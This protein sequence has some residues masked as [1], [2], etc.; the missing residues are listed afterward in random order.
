MSAMRLKLHQ[1]VLKQSKNAVLLSHEVELSC[2]KSWHTH[3]GFTNSAFIHYT[4]TDWC[5]NSY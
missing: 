3:I 2:M 4:P 1:N 5:C